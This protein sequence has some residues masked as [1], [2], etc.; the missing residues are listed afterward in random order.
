MKTGKNR[1]L[2][3]SFKAA[4]DG[5]RESLIFERSFRIMLVIALGA[6]LAM[7]YLPTSKLEKIALLSA[8]FAVLIL[9]L[10]NA[11][12]GVAPLQ[13]RGKNHQRFNGGH[14]PFG[15]HRRGRCRPFDF[16]PVYIL[17]NLISRYVF[18]EISSSFSRRFN[19][20]FA[21]G[22]FALG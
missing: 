22:K 3:E 2:I 1:S 6:T 11:A 16:R 7:I 19:R 20:F 5:F 15:Q 10:I 13:R 12:V 18:K 4:F 21:G 9:E 14:C 8:I 17:A